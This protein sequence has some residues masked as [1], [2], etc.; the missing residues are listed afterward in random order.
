MA[1]EALEGGWGDDVGL[2]QKMC[3][4]EGGGQWDGHGQLGDGETTAEVADGQ[5]VDG[6]VLHRTDA[7]PGKGEIV[8]GQVD[9]ERRDRLR[10][11]HTATHVIG[12]AAREVLGDH[13]R[14]AGAQ[15]GI[16]SSRL[17]V[18]HYDRISRKQAHEI[19]RVANELVR[20]NLPVSQEW[21]ERNAAEAEYGFDLYQGGV[22][23]G[24]SIRLIHVGEGDVPACAGTP[25]DLSLIPL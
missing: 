17:D 21:P 19:E 1:L 4:P 24:T 9:A 22:P 18:R 20:E 6:V 12:H 10:A 7:D 13:V 23:P 14:Q 25:V 2:D 11:H 5:S 16:D 15:K 8:R 3:D